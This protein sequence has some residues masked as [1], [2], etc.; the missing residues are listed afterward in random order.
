MARIVVVGAGACGLSQ[1]LMLA[2]DDHEVTLLERDPQP[3]PASARAA[4]GE[5]ERRGVNQFRM[6]HLFAARWRQVIEAELPEVAAALDAAGGLRSNPVAGAPG[7][8]TGGWRDGDERFEMLTARRP[9]V[10]AVLAE[11]ASRSPG[12]DVR[13]GVPVAG[14]RTE[15]GRRGTG[16]PGIPHVTGVRTE[17]GDD[18]EADLVVDA[19]GRRSPFAG[20]LAAVGAHPVQDDVEESGFVYYARHFRS[21]DGS[22]PPA[23]GAPLQHYDSVG[24]VTLPADNGTWGVG[25]VTSAKDAALRRLADAETWTRVVSAYPLIAHWIDAEPLDDRPAV[26]AKIEDRRRRF[27]VGGAPVATGVV[28]VGDSWAC[29]NPSLGRGASI[30]LI[31]AQALR[32][33]LRASPLDDHMGFARGWDAATDAT[34]GPWFDSTLAFDRHRLAEIEAQIAGVP[35]LPDDPTWS[36]ARSLE[37]AAYAD[38]DAL[39]AFAA[40]MNVL[41]LPQ[42]ALAE[43]GLLDVVR[44]CGAGWE[45]DQAPGPSRA[46]LLSVLAG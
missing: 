18:L 38:P 30:G 29:T 4:W 14:L 7:H 20:W 2:A 28:A 8:V 22:I 10:E 40:V 17:A 12:V 6:I 36:L 1:A 43:P 41:D 33:H 15:N 25:V 32:D 42:V 31:H 26:M 3:P 24:T 37:K 27:V 13:R 9:V 19:G 21:A 44:R 5:W 34:A 23:F 46:E 16:G 11:V 35:Y 45:D 39:R